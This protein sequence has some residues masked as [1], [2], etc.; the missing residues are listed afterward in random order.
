LRRPASELLR[1]AETDDSD[2]LEALLLRLRTREEWIDLGTD[3]HNLQVELNRELPFNRR[4]VR[5]QQMSAVLGLRLAAGA[6]DSLRI[7]ILASVALV[8]DTLTEL[9]PAL[10]DRLWFY[11]QVAREAYEATDT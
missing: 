8:I 9:H 5:G 1:L 6:Q 4:A 11:G 3:L 7:W 2:G 10:E